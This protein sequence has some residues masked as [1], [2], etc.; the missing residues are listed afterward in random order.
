MT[1]MEMPYSPRRLENDTHDYAVNLIS[2]RVWENGG[3]LLVDGTLR[4][5]LSTPFFHWTRGGLNTIVGSRIQG[6]NM[7]AEIE[8]GQ[9]AISRGRSIDLVARTTGFVQLG[10]L[11][12]GFNRRIFRIRHSRDHAFGTGRFP[13]HQYRYGTCNRIG[14]YYGRTR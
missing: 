12:F 3:H 14:L 1:L 8:N 4:I 2:P 7:E 6:I 5:R 13:R 10:Y 11:Q 9:L